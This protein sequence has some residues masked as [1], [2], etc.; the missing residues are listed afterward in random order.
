VIKGGL[1]RHSKNSSGSRGRTYPKGHKG[2]INK[3][4][5]ERE[6]KQEKINRE[7]IEKKDRE[8]PD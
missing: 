8:N 4:R 2:T 1:M 7:W 5:T 6:T 3:G